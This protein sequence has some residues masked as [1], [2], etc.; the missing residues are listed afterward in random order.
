MLNLKGKY[1][2][3]YSSP[4]LPVKGEVIE[5]DDTQILVQS[6]SWHDNKPEHF[7]VLTKCGLFYDTKESFDEACRKAAEDRLRRG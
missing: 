2:L 7:L 6:Y 3:H 4:G 1:V 5:E